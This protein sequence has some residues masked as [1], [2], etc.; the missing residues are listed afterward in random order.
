MDYEQYRKFF[1]EN[2]NY[3]KTI[4]AEVT[5]LR[6][7][8]AE[9]EI[10]TDERH[11]NIHGTVHGGVFLS[12]ADTVVGAASRSYGR[13][14]VSLEGKLNFL[15]PVPVDGAPMKATARA[16]HAGNRT[17]VYDCQIYTSGGV[18]AAAGVFTMYMLDKPL[19]CETE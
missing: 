14:S 8:Y 11:R 4:G 17:G 10:I 16:L 2:S 3:L 15:R 1:N 9:A 5:V 12:L 19:E 6:E 13:S 7:G 18:L